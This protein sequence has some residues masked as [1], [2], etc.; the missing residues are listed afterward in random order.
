MPPKKPRPQKQPRKKYRGVGKKTAFLNA[1]RALGCV[2]EAA[3]AV[4]MNRGTH[5]AWLNEPNGKYKTEFAATTE[6]VGG[7]L[8]E[9]AMKWARRGHFEPFTY[10][11]RPQFASRK[12]VM[13]KLESGETAFE[14]EL[15]RGAKV[16]ERR[17]VITN[18]GEM[19]GI[20]R[21]SEGLLWHLL[22]AHMPEKYGPPAVA[23]LEITG[24][25][26]APLIPLTCR[27][28]FGDG[29]NELPESWRR[30]D[31]PGTAT[32]PVVSP[33][34]QIPLPPEAL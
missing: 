13:C 18:D 12:R 1:F 25:N 9:D 26:G 10:K 31:A 33:G 27:L 21:R 7:L 24:K 3:A 6:E 2:S 11:G 16:T 8:E 5:Y 17:S 30:A 28:M 29:I 22:Q 19:L 4:G 15:P 20:Y 23:K 14:D 34:P 32:A